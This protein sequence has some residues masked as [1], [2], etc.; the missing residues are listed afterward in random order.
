MLMERIIPVKF[1][2]NDLCNLFIKEFVGTEFRIFPEYH[3]WDLVFTRGKV[4]LGV[5]AKLTLNVKAIAQ[6]ILCDGA[7]FK[8][9]LVNEYK[10]KLLDPYIIILNELKI[11]LISLNHGKFNILNGY[12]RGYDLKWLFKWRHR[13]SVALSIPNFNYSTNAGVASPRRVSLNNINLVKLELFALTQPLH[14][15]TLDQ[16]RSFGFDRVPRQYFFYEWDSRMWQLDEM[17]SASRDY[18]HIAAGI[19]GNKQNELLS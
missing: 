18:P 3:D 9:I 4:I 1:T 6:T 2:E 5:Q 8:A 13:P 15:V 7:H 10:P 16:I 11:M 12:N 14:R 17:H 19:L